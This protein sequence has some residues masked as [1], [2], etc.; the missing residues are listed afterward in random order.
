MDGLDYKLLGEL[1]D[2]GFQRSTTL[3]YLLGVGERTIRKRISD[4]RRKGIIKIIAVPN[5]VLFG[6]KAWVFI[7]CGSRAY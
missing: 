7:S 1:Q 6:Y 2:K 3:A 4:M 5:P